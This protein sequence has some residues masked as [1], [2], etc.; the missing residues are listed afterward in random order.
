MRYFASPTK[1][2]DAVELIVK[3]VCANTPSSKTD[4]AHVILC[5]AP[6]GPGVSTR[7]WAASV[8][9]HRTRP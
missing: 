7:Y 2:F 4:L 5:S 9:Q 6:A 3:P 1:I 8:A